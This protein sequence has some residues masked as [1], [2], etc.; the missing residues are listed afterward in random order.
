MYFICA[1]ETTA[2]CAI[3]QIWWYPATTK[4]HLEEVLQAAFVGRHRNDVVKMLVLV[5][6]CEDFSAGQGEGA[7]IENIKLIENDINQLGGQA[8]YASVEISTGLPYFSLEQ[9]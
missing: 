7:A 5:S 1:D 9:L 2:V 8:K 3:C 6:V 4:L